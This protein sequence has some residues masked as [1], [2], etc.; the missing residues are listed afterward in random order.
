V[1]HVERFRSGDN[2][3]PIL[4]LAYSNARERNVTFRDTAMCHL[5]SSIMQLS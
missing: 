4:E 2:G 1:G 3:R 5:A